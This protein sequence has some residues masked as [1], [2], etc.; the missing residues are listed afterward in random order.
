M[1]LSQLAILR[2]EA[3]ISLREMVH[4]SVKVVS[5]IS[6]T[7]T[8]EPMEAKIIAGRLVLVAISCQLTAI[9]CLLAAINC[10]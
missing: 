10:L 9:S 2:P 3:T 6:R 1:I 5:V 7:V 8:I 4:G